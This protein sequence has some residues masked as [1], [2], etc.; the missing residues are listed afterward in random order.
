MTTTMPESYLGLREKASTAPSKTVTLDTVLTLI[1]PQWLASKESASM[2]ESAWANF[3]KHPQYETI[4]S[5]VKDKL[6]AQGCSEAFADRF[7]GDKALRQRTGKLCR[8]FAQFG[9]SMRTLQEAEIFN[10]LMDPASDDVSSIFEQMD[11]R[12]TFSQVEAPMTG[13]KLQ[14][15]R[16]KFVIDAFEHLPE[17]EEK[18]AYSQALDSAMTNLGLPPRSWDQLLENDELL[19]K[20]LADPGV[21][22]LYTLANHGIP[23][24]M[25]DRRMQVYW[26]DNPDGSREPAITL[27]NFSRNPES[28]DVS[29]F[30]FT[31]TQESRR[32]P[33]TGEVE[34]QRVMK[35]GAISIDGK[36]RGKGQGMK[37]LMGLMT[38]PN[39]LK[40]K[41]M[42]FEADIAIGSYTWT[43]IADLDTPTMCREFFPDKFKENGPP[44]WDAEKEH[45]MRVMVYREYVMPEYKERIA[46]AMATLPPETIAEHRRELH[47]MDLEFKALE[48]ISN[49]PE[50]TVKYKT[51]DAQGKEK[52]QTLTFDDLQLE[53]LANLGSDL[54]I[55]HF[56]DYGEIQTPGTPNTRKGHLGKAGM[57]DLKWYGRLPLGGL[58]MLKAIGKLAGRAAL[59][60]LTSKLF[61]GKA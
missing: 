33:K 58:S 7:C 35:D 6:H 26:K 11:L 14:N 41:N 46:K 21:N 38:M 8:N 2:I 42:E 16:M 39:K 4:I 37:F 5:H 57:M 44:P 17:C 61:S 12:R 47:N 1:N 43:R 27:T 25:A 50:A 18:A 56:N 54:E 9:E 55:F 13:K 19:T 60:S 10:E 23:S 32:N 29:I 40:T 49:Q 22:E 36:T 59:K 24:N 30:N 45:E 3:A 15:S 28:D 31:V 20:F 34:K 48:A 53:R 52:E 51:T